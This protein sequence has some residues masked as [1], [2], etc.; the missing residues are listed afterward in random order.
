M[1]LAWASIK[2]GHLP[3]ARTNL[4]RAEEA[5]EEAKEL[6]PEWRC[7]ARVRVA[8][9]RGEIGEATRG[10]DL[11]A[12]ARADIERL[13]HRS[14]YTLK[15]I[16]LAQ[17]E[18][19]DRAAARATVRALDAAILSP[20]DRRKGHWS[21][22]LN[23]L[24]E[25]Q[26]AAGDVEEAFRNCL[27][28]PPMPGK[29]K[30]APLQRQASMLADLASAAADANHQSRAGLDPAR[31]MTAEEKVARLAIV[32]RAVE[33][34][35]ALPDPSE[36]RPSLAASLSRL[37][38]FDE[39]VRVALRIDQK[40]ILSPGQIDAIW[41]LGR[42]SL[43]QSKAGDYEGA[44]AT[45]REAARVEVPPK[46]DAQKSR[47]TLANGFVVAR[48]YD[49]ALKIAETLD[50]VGRALVLSQV[51]R[52]KR[53]VGDRAGAEPLFRRALRDAGEFL[54]SPPPPTPPG[55][56]RPP[57]REGP[58]AADPKAR[59]QAEALTLLILIHA[60]AGDWASAERTF[61]FM[62][63]ESRHTRV[64][65]LQIAM[66]RSHSG[67]VAG[68]LAW[69]RSLPSGSLRA[70]ALRGLAL[71]IFGEDGGME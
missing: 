3:E 7:Y 38:A 40:K 71:G 63:P 25:A 62:A 51:A 31:P 61:G 24:A 68:A 47:H 44:R 11:L 12:V 57:A 53:L 50:P 2:S 18:L 9:A 66:S 20:E 55:P 54:H 36:H 67:D 5:E 39:A 16:A 42:I 48:G 32:R 43:D 13:G 60:R 30:N 49:E 52:H 37:G 64:A 46:A 17:A 59:H 33:A 4:D 23:E 22:D 19:G 70:W 27:P 21:S 1:A 56:A 15:N 28:G 45:L 14:V 8:Q 35:E 65:A 26:L 58:D 10:L 41:A 29:P 6:D 34:V 69:A